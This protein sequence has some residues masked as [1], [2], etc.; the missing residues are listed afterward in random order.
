MISVI[1]LSCSLSFLQANEAG[2]KEAS[3]LKKELDETKSQLAN[4]KSGMYQKIIMT[5]D[6]KITASRHLCSVK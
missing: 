1:P 4:T 3:G 5:R 2:D 6:V